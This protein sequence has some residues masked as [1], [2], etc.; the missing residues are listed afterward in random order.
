M[1]E[2]PI[3]HLQSMRDELLV[4]YHTIL[5]TAPI[6]TSAGYFRAQKALQRDE[7][8]T[9]NEGEIDAFLPQHLKRDK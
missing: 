7:E 9:F 8:L 2:R 1:G 3:E 5:K 6:T 4:T